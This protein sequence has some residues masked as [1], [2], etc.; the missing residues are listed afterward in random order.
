[1][2]PGLHGKLVGCFSGVTQQSMKGHN[3]MDSNA[4]K[5]KKHAKKP[6]V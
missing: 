5:K 1:V 4:K 6:E 3:P 2:L